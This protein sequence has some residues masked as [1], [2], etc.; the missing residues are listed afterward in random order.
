MK[1]QE[2]ISESFST[3][4]DMTMELFN[5]FSSQED[6]VMDSSNS[7]SSQEAMVDDL[8][9]TTRSISTPTPRDNINKYEIQGV[10]NLFSFQTPN[11]PI[12]CSQNAMNPP[13]VQRTGKRENWFNARPLRVMELSE[14]DVK[15]NQDSNNDHDD[16]E[17]D[18]NPFVLPFKSPPYITIEYDPQEENDLSIAEVRDRWN[19]NRVP[20]RPRKL[21]NEYPQLSCPSDSTYHLLS[22]TGD[23]L[24]LSQMI[25]DLSVSAPRS[26]YHLNPRPMKNNV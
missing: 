13:P 24:S 1:D 19:I 9:N 23:I 16:N 6:M 18:E 14:F 17:H 2:D 3:Q 26:R 11:P 20:L 21:P 7:F 4:R 15:S 25:L 22:T 8:D 12:S 10:E 5:S